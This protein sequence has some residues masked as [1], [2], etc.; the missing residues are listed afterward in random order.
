MLHNTAGIVLRN[1]KYGETSV[2]VTVFTERFGIQSYLINGVRTNSP[3]TSSRA[4]MLQP[5]CILEMVVYHNEL[6]NL[7]RVRELK[8][9]VLYRQ[10]FFDVRKN[11]VALFMVELLLRCLKQPEAQPDLFLFAEDAFTHLDEADETISANFP[12]YYM[13]HLAYFF[14]FRI[15]DDYS[16]RNSILDLEEGNFVAERPSHPHYLEGQL[17]EISSQLLKVMQPSELRQLKLNQEIRKQLLQAYISYYTFH[18]PG[19]GVL[20]SIPVLQEIF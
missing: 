16:I 8:W 1:I 15:H 12:L 20:K 10:I 19:F 18:I 14:G 3:K 11:A 13:L 5:A 2:V 4:G 7:Q 17:S 6:K 9:K